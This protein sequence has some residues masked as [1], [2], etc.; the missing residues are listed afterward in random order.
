MGHPRI[1]RA[2]MAQQGHHYWPVPVRGTCC[3]PVKSGSPMLRVAVRVPVAAGVKVTEMVQVP[4]AGTLVAQVLVWTKSL[5]L[6]PEIEMLVMGRAVVATLLKVMT[7]AALVV[8]TVCAAKV[9]EVGC[10][11]TAVPDPVIRLA[12]WPPPAVNAPKTFRAAVRPPVCKGVKATF[13][14]QL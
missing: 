13:I 4:P 1:E 2:T 5:A 8:P 6:V 12:C 9:R 11:E 10:R 7:F 3:G 14:M